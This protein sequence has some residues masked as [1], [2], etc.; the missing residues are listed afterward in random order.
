MLISQ[1]DRRYTE[2]IG[3]Q[4]AVRFTKK[5]QVDG[6][7]EGKSDTELQKALL[8]KSSTEHQAKKK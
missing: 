8:E 3:P 2:G 6:K 5:Q 1:D 4:N 7:I